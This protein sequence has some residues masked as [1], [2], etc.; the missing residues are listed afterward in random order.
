MLLRFLEVLLEW[1]SKMNLVGVSGKTRIVNELILDSM[2]PVPCLPEKGNMVDFGSG[3]GFPAMI[4]KI[5]KPGLDMRLIES[6]GKK[7]NFLKHAIRSLKLKGISPVNDRIESV[8]DSLKAW[9]CEIVTSRAMASLEKVVDLSYPLI[10]PGGIIVGFLGKSG[11]EEIEKNQ[12]FILK[13]N[14]K[15]VKSISYNLPGAESGRTTV[16][17]QK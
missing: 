17:L 7:C 8:S 12:G 13:Y 16:I 4:L 15:L 3:A 11:K 5:L 9:G 14:L 10:E 1:N 6:N 2:I